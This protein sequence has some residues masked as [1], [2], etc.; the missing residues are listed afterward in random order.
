MAK[1]NNQRLKILLLILALIPFFSFSGINRFGGTLTQIF[2]IL[3]TAILAFFV[4][5]KKSI[6]EDRFAIF[7]LLY[8]I[9]TFV[10]TA[11]YQG[12][13]TGLL[14]SIISYTF[15]FAL[16]FLDF[17]SVLSAIAILGYLVTIANFLTIIISGRSDDAIYFVGGKNRL[18]IVLIPLLMIILLYELRQFGKIR[19]RAK[20]CW[21]VGILSIVLAGSGTGLIVAGFAILFAILFWKANPSK[22]III[23]I[24]LALYAL[25]ILSSNMVLGSQVWINVTSGLG[26]RSDLTDRTLV[27][28]SLLRMLRHNWLLG[29]GRGATNTFINNWGLMASVNEAHNAVLELF[30]DGGVVGFILYAIAFTISVKKTD[31]STKE[32]KVIFIAIAVIMIN[33]LTE[34]V[35]TIFTTTL[36]LAIANYYSYSSEPHIIE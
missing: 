27:W 4:I 17:D 22:Y 6:P 36:I 9:E 33:G 1:S 30:L 31:T 34:S 12:I 15:L 13:S 5:A 29:L 25:L 8:S 14:F 28:G 11:H 20:L 26:K 24:I 21:A 3:G 2:L 16:F 10:V 19:L 7:F 35:T 18:S 23:G 32:G